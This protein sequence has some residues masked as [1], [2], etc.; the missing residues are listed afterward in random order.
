MD[1]L[2]MVMPAYNEEDAI[3]EVIEEWY[4]VVERHHGNGKSRMVVIDDGSRDNTVAILRKKAE[5]RPLLEVMTKENSGHGDTL[6]YGYRYALGGGG[7][8][9]SDR[10]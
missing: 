8:R 10:F 6:L 1:I 2:Y 4:P 5:N 3:G 9:I 7:I